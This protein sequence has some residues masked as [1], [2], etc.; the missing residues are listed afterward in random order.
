ME[1]KNYIDRAGVEPPPEERVKEF[2][3]TDAGMSV[4]LLVK[5]A[6]PSD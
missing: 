1:Q 3:Q 6:L 4:Y 5:G 2:V